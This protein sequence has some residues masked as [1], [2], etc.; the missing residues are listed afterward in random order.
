M[1]EKKGIETIEKVLSFLFDLGFQVADILE[2]KK[3]SVTEGFALALKLPKIWSTVKD[4][5]EFKEEIK[6]ID[7]EELQ[8]L[9]VLL[10]ELH[11]SRK[12]E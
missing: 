4:F 3:V 8:R 1:E 12:K 5:S 7:P 6:D 2:D 11:E 10:I 9:L